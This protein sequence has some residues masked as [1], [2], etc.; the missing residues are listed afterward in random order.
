MVDLNPIMV[1]IPIILLLLVMRN[2]ENEASKFPS[3]H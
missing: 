1:I 3:D 2:P